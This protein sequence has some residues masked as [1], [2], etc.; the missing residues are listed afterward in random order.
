MTYEQFQQ[1]KHTLTTALAEAFAVKLK[2]MG[3]NIKGI[4]WFSS[5]A[6]EYNAKL[7]KRIQC[8]IKK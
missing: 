8:Q 7:C 1:Y 6:E 4:S 3:E 5:C 2:D